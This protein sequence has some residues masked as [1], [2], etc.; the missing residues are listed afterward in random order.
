MRI[1]LLTGL[2]V[3]CAASAF[4]GQTAQ[5]PAS[6]AASGSANQTMTLIG[7]VGGGA[8]ATDPFMLSDASLASVGSATPG[9]VTTATPAATPSA[10]A[11]PATP[12]AAEAPATPTAAGCTG[13]ADRTAAGDGRHFRNSGNSRDRRH[14]RDGGDSAR[15][16]RP[17]RRSCNGG[18]DARC[19]STGD[20]SRLVARCHQRLSA[21]RRRRLRLPRTARADRRQPRP[22]CFVG[23]FFRRHAGRDDHRRSRVQSAERSG[24]LRLLP[25]A[26]SDAS[27]RR[28]GRSGKTVPG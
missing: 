11:A 21:E 25:S 12:A 18:D 15:R 22:T 19:S 17:A 16:A 5:P 28:R 4:A 8:A 13:D 1:T 6:A 24:D 7:C 2:V 14:R 3:A 9:Q 26:V 27:D 10:A 20:Q 23:D